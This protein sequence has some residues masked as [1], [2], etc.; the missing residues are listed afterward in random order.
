M[1]VLPKELP[2][3]SAKKSWQCLDGRNGEKGGSLRGKQTPFKAQVR[4]F[5]KK[6]EQIAAISNSKI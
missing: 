5:P 6:P 2:T 1:I 4:N 3:S